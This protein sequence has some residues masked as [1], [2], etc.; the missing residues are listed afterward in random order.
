MH[1]FGILDRKLRR[2]GLYPMARRIS[3]QQSAISNQ[4]SAISNQQSGIR[5]HGNHRGA[6]QRV[7]FDV[8]VERAEAGNRPE[9]PKTAREEEL[10][11]VG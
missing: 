10:E 5:D 9:P 7:S 11:A 3:N 1:R 6:V 4:Q 8:F 2:L